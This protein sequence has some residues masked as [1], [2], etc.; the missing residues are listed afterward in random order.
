MLDRTADYIEEMPAR[1]MMVFGAVLFVALCA[2]LAA[3]G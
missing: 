2:L 1:T 3:T